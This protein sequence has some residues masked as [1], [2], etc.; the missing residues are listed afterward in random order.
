MAV[1][2]GAKQNQR[3]KVGWHWL[4][5]MS[6]YVDVA[7]S[8][9]SFSSVQRCRLQCSLVYVLLVNER[10]YQTVLAIALFLRTVKL[11][12]VSAVLKCFGN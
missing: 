10:A 1:N 5:C 4:R 12:N 11:V 2:L 7:V 3:Q 8:S 9:F 6:L